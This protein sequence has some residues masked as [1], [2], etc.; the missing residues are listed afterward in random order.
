MHRRTFLR[1]SVCAAAGTPAL[2]CTSSARQPPRSG[3]PRHDPS[4][5][6]AAVLDADRK[7]VTKLAVDWTTRG[8]SA[9]DLL[10]AALLAGLR[11]VNPSPIGGQVHAMMMVASAA[12]VTGTLRG[13]D[14]LLPA[15][16]NLDRTKRSQKRDA[17]ARR[18]DWQ[19]PAPPPVE[20]APVPELVDT[21]ERAMR[22]WDVDAADQAI[23]AL[24]DTLS[25]DDFFE[26]LWPWA[27]RDFRIIGHKAIYATQTYR[28]LQ[29]LGWRQGRDAVRS[30]GFG[31]LD[32]N[33]YGRFSEDDSAAIL[34]LFD[35]N[36]ERTHDI[37]AAWDRGAPSHEDALT[38][39]TKL[40]DADAD[41][42][43][44]AV[45][46]ALR[47]GVAGLS[48]WDAV[49]LH[50][51]E[52]VARHPSIAGVHPVTSVN[53]LYRAASISRVDATRRLLLLQAASW[54]P[55]FGAF[56]ASRPDLPQHELRVDAKPT[57]QTRPEDPFAASTREAAA[58]A[59][60]HQLAQ[61]DGAPFAARARAVLVRKAQDDHDYKYTVAALEEI[62]AAQ[63][64]TRP[65]LAAAA[66]SYLQLANEDDSALYRRA[67]PLL[68]ELAAR[69]ASAAA[70][71]GR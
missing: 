27:A 38:L 66:M 49:R 50:A 20:A 21:L 7:E 57:A 6:A 9:R 19:M 68:D 18:G 8:A 22:S 63:P 43:A 59:A 48:A 25:L 35:D 28:A 47:R 51:F 41:G 67:R 45:V 61:G 13:P 71:R 14:K 11:E 52:L 4:D 10:G 42:A 34:G 5:M 58:A 33:P 32:Q 29:D 70:A 54:M 31:V 15:L 69:Q 44:K 39:L 17:N 36:R 37:P 53:A 2:A 30:L 46:Q 64:A 26:V 23:T 40:R 62:G 12:E 60:H 65:F 55:L 3:G 24:H 1:A 56:L 16:F